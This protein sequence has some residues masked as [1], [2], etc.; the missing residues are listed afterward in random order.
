MSGTAARTCTVVPVPGPDGNEAR[1]D[2]SLRDCRPLADYRSHDAYVLLGDPGAGRTTA[3]MD[4]VEALGEETCHPVSARDFLAI[5]D[6]TAPPGR[7]LFIDGLDEVRAGQRDA[8]T[9]FEALRRRL[10]KLGRPRFRLSCREADWPGENDRRHLARVSPGGQVTVLRL[11]P[12]TGADIG[13]VLA[14]RDDIPDPGHFVAMA[15]DQGVD[16][17]LANPQTPG[18]LA[19]VVAGGGEWP[20]SR[21]ETF[22]QSSRRIVREHN[23]EHD[24]ASL[25]SGGAPGVDRTLAAAG[26]LCAVHLLTG[27]AGF[28]KLPGE[29]GHGRLGPGQC[30]YEPPDLLRHALRTKLFKG[31]LEGRPV[32]VHRHVAEYLAAR[33]PGRVVEERKLPARRVVALMAGHDGIVVT[34]M[35][36]LSA[37]FAA[38]CRSARARLIDR[39]PIGVV[40]YGDVSPPAAAARRDSCS[41][42]PTP[43]HHPRARTPTTHH[44][45]ARRGAHHAHRWGGMARG[46]AQQAPPARTLTVGGE[47]YSLPPGEPA[48]TPCRSVLYR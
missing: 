6:P 47:G 15:R 11:D 14:Y 21:L 44:H 9:A 43:G 19:D 37:W 42:L 17:L 26:R 16:G 48:G 24:I 25:G 8:R 12:L 13:G 36:G 27:T 20:G 39:D 3:F 5:E 38:R 1:G 22:G 10:A 46:S 34:E 45:H 28:S 7:T 41:T 23:E 35:R 29:E 31:E 40:Q 32:P 18:M 30:G 2:P 4:E 33:H